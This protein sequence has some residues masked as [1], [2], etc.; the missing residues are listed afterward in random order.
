M[1]PPSADALRR[2]GNRYGV[3]LALSGQ[4]GVRRM[5]RNSYSQDTDGT[6]T[7]LD[8]INRPEP[9]S[10]RTVATAFEDLILAIDRE[11]S[12]DEKEAEAAQTLHEC[13]NAAIE[14]IREMMLD[15]FAN[16][17]N[18]LAKGGETN[19][20]TY[21]LIT[22]YAAVYC[23]APYQEAGLLKLHDA[24][25]GSRMRSPYFAPMRRFSAEYRP[26]TSD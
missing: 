16:A 22:G 10:Y 24:I 3:P 8:E 20:K 7:P 5:L 4:T 25:Y 18:A 9:T 1:L 6:G 21:E 19:L 14:H 23:S 11:N 15:R 26:L 12:S 17:I 2:E 13:E